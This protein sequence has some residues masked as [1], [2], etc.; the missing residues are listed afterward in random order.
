VPLV[1]TGGDLTLDDVVGVARG[2]T[3]VELAPE[4]GRAHV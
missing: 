4:I 2:D 3:R 1:L